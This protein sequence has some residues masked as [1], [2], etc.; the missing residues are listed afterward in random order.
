MNIAR[1]QNTKSYLIELIVALDKMIKQSDSIDANGMD[2]AVI[3][4]GVTDSVPQIEKFELLVG[5]PS[6]FVNGLDFHGA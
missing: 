6:S 4:R 3:A 1:K 2:Q 5:N